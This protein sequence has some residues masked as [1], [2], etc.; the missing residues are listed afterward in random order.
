M[1]KL[2]LRALLTTALATSMM[3]LT[4]H[5]QADDLDRQQKRM[6]H[7]IEKISKTL[8]LND[9]QHTQ[10]VTLAKAQHAQKM[11]SKNKMR[12]LHKQLREAQKQS[13]AD[14]NDINAIADNIAEQTRQNVLLRV[15][16]QQALKKILNDE[17]LAKLEKIRERKTHKHDRHGDKY[18]R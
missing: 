9:S 6:T 7:K 1:K 18:R 14:S 5:V 10:W 16:H 8:D 11:E 2:T 3:A 4:A 15:E 17:Q 13:S 12:E